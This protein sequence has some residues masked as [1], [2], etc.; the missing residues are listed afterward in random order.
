MVSYQLF[1]LLTTIC[2]FQRECVAHQP[3]NSSVLLDLFLV[4]LVGL[5]EAGA[6]IETELV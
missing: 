3:N 5:L 4:S 6:R 1:F 2:F